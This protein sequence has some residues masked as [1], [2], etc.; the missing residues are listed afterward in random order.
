MNRSNKTSVSQVKPLF[1]KLCFTL[2]HLESFYLFLFSF[3]FSWLHLQ[4]MEVQGPGV[5]SELHLG[6]P[7][8]PQQHQ[9]QATSVTYAIAYNNTGSLTHGARPGIEPTSSQ[10]MTVLKLMSH[11]G[12]YQKDFKNYQ[13]WGFTP[14]ILIYLFWNEAWLCV[15]FKSS[16]NDSN[17][18]LCL[19]ITDTTSQI[20]QNSTEF[21]ALKNQQQNIMQEKSY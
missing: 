11:N 4:H 12:N 21:Y 1:L 16:P 7:P 9:I 15:Y 14:K 5:K 6:P 2:D 8:Q 3:F 19:R 20:T 13:Y 17:V 18:H 10:T